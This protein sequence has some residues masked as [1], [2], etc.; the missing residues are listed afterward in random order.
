ME[1][2]KNLKKSLENKYVK[3]FEKKSNEKASA[4]EDQINENIN[5][6]H[7][8][9]IK[10]EKGIDTSNEI[11]QDEN[12]KK[13]NSNNLYN[14]KNASVKD[15]GNII[16]KETNILNYSSS[17]LDEINNRDNTDD[18]NGINKRLIKREDET[19]GNLIG[20]NNKR[21]FDNEIKEGSSKRLKVEDCTTKDC[22]L[23]LYNVLNNLL[24]YNNKNDIELFMKKIKNNFLFY[25]KECECQLK[26][27]QKCYVQS[28]KLIKEIVCENKNA[29]ISNR[30]S[31]VCTDM[32]R[33]SNEI[34]KIDKKRKILNNIMNIKLTYR[35]VEMYLFT[36]RQFCLLLKENNNFISLILDEE[37]IE[38]KNYERINGNLLTFQA[39][40]Y[41]DIKKYT[42]KKKKTKLYM[43]DFLKIVNKNN[44]C[45]KDE[46]SHFYT[47][48]CLEEEIS[49][50]TNAK[51]DL[52]YLMIK[53][54]E[55]AEEFAK[56]DQRKVTS[57]NKLAL[58]T[59][60]IKSIIDKYNSLDVEHSKY[61]STFYYKMVHVQD[62]LN[63]NN[64]SVLNNKKP[65]NF[66]FN[67]KEQSNNNDVFTY[68][69]YN[70]VTKTRNKVK[71]TAPSKSKEEDV[72]EEYISIN[73]YTKDNFDISIL[74]DIKYLKYL[75]VQIDVSYLFSTD[76]L[77]AKTDLIEF[78]GLN[79]GRKF[80]SDIY[81]NQDHFV[82]FSEDINHFHNFKYGFPFFW[83]NALAEK[84]YELEALGETVQ[85][86][87][88]NKKEDNNS[89]GNSNSSNKGNTTDQS[90]KEKLHRNQLLE[91]Y[92]WH[93]NRTLDVS[94]FFSKIF[95][96]GKKKSYLGYGTFGKFIIITLKKIQSVSL[97][98]ISYFDIIM[99]EAYLK[100]EQENNDECSKDNI[101]ACCF[102][103]LYDS[104]MVKAYIS[105]PFNGK[106]PC[107]SVFLT[108]K[109]YSRRL[110][111]LQDYLNT[112]V[113]NKHSKVEDTQRQIILTLQIAKLR[114]G[115]HKYYKSFSKNSTLIFDEEIS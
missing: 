42:L 29:I 86:N 70:V 11:I 40:N 81:S 51:A 104:C 112:T 58:F 98:Q 60:S 92:N 69:K 115:A 78:I 111:K 45:S 55:C 53:K 64:I 82:L 23:S 35:I 73:V 3:Y 97:Q 14:M 100:E 56:Q 108:K 110:K 113:I 28:E 99:E 52:L 21:I 9:N 74:P 95:T 26:E 61:L 67:F 105:I 38:K 71:N 39:K 49:E 1:N 34:L 6:V 50:R 10:K 93:L 18:T 114:E 48:K 103:Q 31:S 20:N 72:H 101:Y 68:M 90:Q 37:N 57:Y 76:C 41:E 8:L 63:I 80:L 66:L 89:S 84:P 91:I 2:I 24:F 19:N 107:F 77:V 46:V 22:E 15:R 27:L 83:L 109:K 30:N 94:I 32:Q 62:D 7:T 13:G 12:E 87:Q 16:E 43:D 47:L 54:K 65:F 102:I 88:L 59:N 106:E 79:D 17:V 85:S 5:N 25:W 4:N 44:T 33:E 75:N 96:R 36:M